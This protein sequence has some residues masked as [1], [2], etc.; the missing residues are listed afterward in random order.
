[1]TFDELSW[2]VE[3][4]CQN[5]W[6]S[7]RQVLLDGWLLRAAG[8]PN[9]RTNSVNPLRFSSSDPT[10]VIDQ[11]ED[12]YGSLGQASLFRV[13]SMVPAMEGPLE[14]RGYVAEGGTCTLFVDFAERATRSA[15]DI[16]L[17]NQASARWKAAWAEIQNAS[18]PAARI[19]GEMTELIALPKAFAS[20]QRDGKI[21]SIAYGVIHKRFLVVEAVATDPGSRQQGHAARTIAKLIDWAQKKRAVAGCLQ[22]VADNEPACALYK[23]LGFNRELY[24]YHYRRKD[25]AR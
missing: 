9:R 7:P 3:E 21:V 17:S 20:Y 24:R 10:D 8:G 11:V 14:R 6:P 19:F 2:S 23:S 5:A 16:E 15:D 13:P 12:I 4:A 18:E 25:I 22:V 1:M